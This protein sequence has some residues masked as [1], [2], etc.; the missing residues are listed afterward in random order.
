MR[1]LTP[2]MTLVLICGAAWAAL[3]QDAGTAQPPSGEQAVAAEAKTQVDVPTPA[4]LRAKIHRTMAELIEAQSA[5]K[6]DPQEI[7]K[8][9]DQLQELRQKLWAQ[10]PAADGRQVGP[11][12]GPGSGPGM[13]LGRGRGRGPAVA[14]GLGP[15][16]GPG[17]GPG[18]G[19]GRGP[20]MGQ[21]AGR[22]RG[23][24]PGPGWGRG[25]G[26][27][28]GYGP[29]PGRGYGPGY[30]RGWGFIDEDRD[31]VCDNFERLWD[32]P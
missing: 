14:P 15:G 8:L 22:G 10:G 24:G 28:R 4:K 12:R 7:Q 18:M 17:R 3:A 5:D 32:R 2:V 11:R 30:G 19:P 16:M 23:Q 13:G 26:P 25:G 29:G 21:G 20:A 6:P 1:R 31:G 27:G 9:S